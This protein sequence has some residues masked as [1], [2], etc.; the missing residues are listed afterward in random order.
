MFFYITVYLIII[1]FINNFFSKKKILESNTGSIHQSFVNNSV[2]LSGGIIIFL[3]VLNLLIYDQALI[4]LVFFLLF[5]LGVYSD[6]NILSSPK[7]R[8][9][10]QIII[11]II[12]VFFSK[13]SVLPT[14]IE[15]I[16]KIF[17]NSILNY[18]FTAFCLMVLINGSNFIDGLNG[19]LIG[20]FLIVMFFIYNLGLLDISDLNNF[21]E[22][23][24][25]ST[26]LFLIVMNFFNK[27]FLG[28]NGAYSLSFLMGVLLIKIYNLN[29]NIS[30]Y[31][32]ILLLWYPCFENL[33][34]IIRKFI[35]KKNPLKP[36][37]NHLHQLIYLFI[38]KKYKLNNLKSNNISSL[39][40]ITFNFMIVHAA[41]W[42]IYYTKYQLL[43]ISISIF[44]YLII[45]FNL[46]NILK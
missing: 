28:D 29:Q 14:R 2:P 27:L 9:L 26:V 33:F 43:I 5:F 11:L 18:F 38:K 6:L 4:G 12:F 15:F 25:L 1:Y 24:I 32:I 34:S 19:L 39:I 22:L 8:F 13:L 46:R 20:Y 30:P 23:F 10:I 16:D 42:D 17:S 45:F 7:K 21:K 40:I 3:P 44:L 35:E 36:D 37:N 31:F 41:S